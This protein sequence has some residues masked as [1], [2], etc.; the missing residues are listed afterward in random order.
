M[1]SSKIPPEPW[2]EQLIA[3]CLASLYLLAL[4]GSPAADQVG[5]TARLWVALLWERQRGGWRQ[6]IDD[7]RIRQAFATLAQSRTRWPSPAVFWEALPKR[8]EPE[9]KL[10]GPGWGREREAE[11]LAGMRRWLRSLGLDEHGN[12]ITQDHAA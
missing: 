6:D 4:D 3:T 2:F 10:L 7:P 12:P 8:P 1:T 5:K 11:A 9:H